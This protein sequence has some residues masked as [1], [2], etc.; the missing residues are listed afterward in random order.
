MRRLA[1]WIYSTRALEVEPV[2]VLFY[3]REVEESEVG[4]YVVLAHT[5]H[6]AT[7]YYLHLFAVHGPLALFVQLPVGGPRR[8]GPPQ[9]M[10]IAHVF[11]ELDVLF[12]AVAERPDLGALSA[13]RRLVVLVSDPHGSAWRW[14]DDGEGPLSARSRPHHEIETV[15]GA[16]LAVQERE[17]YAGSS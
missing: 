6:G 14:A 1:P 5:G 15:R 8:S 3:V 9:A 16:I 13:S 7:G 10:R 17:R 11:A 12:G 2:D 4:A